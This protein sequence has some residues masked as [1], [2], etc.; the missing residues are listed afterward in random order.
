M[1]NSILIEKIPSNML[2]NL[3]DDNAF[4]QNEKYYE[5]S[6]DVFKKLKTIGTL[7]SFL[8]ELTPYYRKNKIHYLEKADKYT[9][10]LTIV[11]HICKANG[12]SYYSSIKYSQSKYEILYK[13]YKD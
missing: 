2:M 7:T 10:F 5:M 4:I 11:R 12:I 13:I 8:E 3:L 1:F 6:L 9:N